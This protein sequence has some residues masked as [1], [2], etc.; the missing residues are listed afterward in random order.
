MR[1]RQSDHRRPHGKP[2]RIGA[3]LDNDIVYSFLHSAHHDHGAVVTIVIV[4]PPCSPRSSRRRPVR[5]APAQ[6]HRTRIT[7]PAWLEGAMRASCSQRRSGPR[8]VLGI[9]YGSRQSIAIGVM[10]TMLAA[11]SASRSD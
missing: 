1:M 7:P 4:S 2:S 3:L 5:S 6:P 9:P 10:A 11:S 8:R